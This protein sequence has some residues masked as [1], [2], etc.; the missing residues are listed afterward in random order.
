MKWLML[1]TVA[2]IATA[3]T[4]NAKRKPASEAFEMEVHAVSMETRIDYRLALE[5]KQFV[6]T[7]Q[8]TGG[9]KRIVLSQENARF[10]YSE[11]IK[12]PQPESVPNSCYRSRVDIWARESGETKPLAKSSCIG[13]NTITSPSYA[14]FLDLLQA[15]I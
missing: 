6:L 11:F 8:S 14:R 10:L 4:A 12:L 13:V 3:A 9:K 2:W 15:A 5:G 7:V 1:L